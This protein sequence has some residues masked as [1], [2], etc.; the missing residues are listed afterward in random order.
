MVFW[1][2]SGAINERKSQI[3]TDIA[4]NRLELPSI[5]RKTGGFY[6]WRLINSQVARVDQGTLSLKQS[7]ALWMECTKLLDRDVYNG[8]IYIKYIL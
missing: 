5:S 8:S 2:S 4:K 1:C 7:L 3:S 6:L